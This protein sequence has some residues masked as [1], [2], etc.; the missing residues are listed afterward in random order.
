MRGIAIGQFSITKQFDIPLVLRGSSQRT[1]ERVVPEIFQDGRLSF[2]KN[3]LRE[4]PFD[5]DIRTFY[6]DRGVKEK[7]LRALYILS[8]GRINLGTIEVQVPDYMEWDYPEIYKTISH[9]MGWKALPDRDEH[10]DC[11]A[12]P[13]VHYLREIR[14]SDLT[15]NTLRYSAEIRLGLRDRSEALQLINEESRNGIKKEYIDYF[16][17]KLEITGDDLEKYMENDLRHM[18]YQRE[19]TAMLIFQKLRAI[20]AK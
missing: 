3:V 13:A 10:V 18:K 11:L 4:H 17:D 1:E 8:G 16:L 2:F 14:C 20:L 6:T 5:E 19:E 12:D 7:I 15:A 9:E